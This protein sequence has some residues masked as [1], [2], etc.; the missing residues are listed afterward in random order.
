MYCHA[1][2]T[3]AL[4][5][6]LAESEDSTELE[7]T[8]TDAVKFCLHAQNEGWGWRYFVRPG[9]NDTSITG[10]MAHAV[11]SAQGAALP[12]GAEEFAKS[13]EGALNWFDAATSATTGR[14][15]YR[16]PGDEGA[17]LAAHPCGS[18]EAPFD[19]EPSEMTAESLFGRLLLG[20]EESDASI[21]LGV[22]LLA[23]Q[24][25][26]WA[27]S[28][29]ERLSKVNFYYW[30]FGS[31]ALL[32]QRTPGDAVWESWRSD[33]LDA[34]IP[35]QRRCDGCEDGSWDPVGQWGIVGGRVYSTAL[36]ALAL[37]A[38]LPPT[39]FNGVMDPGEDGTD[40]GGECAPCPRFRR[41]DV[42]ADGRVDIS[43]PI[44]VLRHLFEME[45]ISECLEAV[46]AN[47][48]ADVD[49]TDA[50]Y[51]LDWLFGS[52]SEPPPPGP[53]E[54]GIDATADALGCLS[55]SPCP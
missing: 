46:D 33:L 9:D 20:R 19:Q 3:L 10:W 22:D 7:G 26:E 16:A 37:V 27:E 51:L 40:C 30:Y 55:F 15:G 8:V 43:D 34:L 13:L 32:R 47:D 6:L 48:D 49:L 23:R 36:G 28:E 35:N 1:N 29:G 50:V 42:N 5:K 54:C 11:H 14:T 12:I 52:G 31:Q 4:A 45:V 25:P 53:R 21:R 39:C 41:G 18:I 24:P 17:L 2:A 44:S 38:A